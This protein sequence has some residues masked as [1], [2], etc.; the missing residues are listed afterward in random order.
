LSSTADLKNK[1]GQ[2]PSGIYEAA[3]YHSVPI[4][5]NAYNKPPVIPFLF[6]KQFIYETG[7]GKV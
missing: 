4:I 6:H 3:L 2:I 7:H 5:S 1:A